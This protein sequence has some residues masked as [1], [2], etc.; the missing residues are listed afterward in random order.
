MWLASNRLRQPL[1]LFHHLKVNPL[2][3][4]CI[5]LFRQFIGDHDL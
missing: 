5:L 2:G 1:W 4:G 3:D